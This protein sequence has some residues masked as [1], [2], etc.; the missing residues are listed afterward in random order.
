MQ[1]NF[2]VQWVPLPAE[3]EG[4]WRHAI[5]L[6]A[7]IIKE[8]AKTMSLELTKNQYRFAWIFPGD[9]ETHYGTFLFD[10]PADARSTQGAMQMLFRNAVIWL[11]DREH[12]RV[13]IPN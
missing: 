2:Q 13:E 6:I 3:R 10:D 11:E 7:E 9:T 4:E 5:E 1:T 12:N 8:Y